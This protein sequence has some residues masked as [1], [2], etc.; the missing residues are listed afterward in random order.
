MQF[1][2]FKDKAGEPVDPSLFSIVS[3]TPTKNS[4]YYEVI[5]VA[6]G[7]TILPDVGYMVRLVPGVLQD[8]NGNVPHENNPWRRIE[9]EQRVG[10]EYPGVVAVDPATWTPD[11]W[12]YRNDVTPVRVDVSKKIDDVIAETGLPGELITFDLSEV[13]KT[14]LL[15]TNEPRDVA[16][17]K[18]QIKWQVD[19]FTNLGQ[20]VNSQSGTVACNDK[21][22]FG[23]DCVENPGN[24]FLMW[25]ARSNTG[26]FV[27]TGVF[28]AKLKFKILSDANVVG[29]KDDTFS[30]GIRRKE[31]K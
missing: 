2:E 24:V 30:L 22:V 7:N 25:D 16:L 15:N 13:G 23:T 17:S 18:V 20:F 28:V 31:N 1:L 14:L 21:D 12:P 8:L 26:R 29:R 3:V 11:K 27:G 5:F 9:G 10:M 6:D 19:Y 4:N